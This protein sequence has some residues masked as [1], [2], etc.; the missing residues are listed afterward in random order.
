MLGF[1]A[2]LDGDSSITLD[3]VEMAEAGWFTRD[4]VRQARDW[5]DQDLP[6]IEGTRLRAIPPRLSISRYL[7]DQWLAGEV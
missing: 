1:I 7:I 6:A 2:R 3:P 4:D 5:T